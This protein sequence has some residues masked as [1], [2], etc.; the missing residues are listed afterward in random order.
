MT[1]LEEKESRRQKRAYWAWIAVCIS[2]GTTFLAARIAIE[3]YPPLLM[4]GTRH[5]V[6]GAVLSVFVTMR[7]VRLPPRESWLGHAVVGALMVGAGNGFLI[8][9]QQFVPS[10]VAAVMASTIP[11]WMVGVEA[12]M[13]GGEHLRAR[14]L[15]GLLIGFGG[16][17]L[18]SSS[19]V[20]L[21]GVGD[22]QF[23]LGVIALQCS[24]CG[25]AIGSAWAKRHKREEN[26]L[27]A[28]A[29]QILFG[30]LLQFLIGT[31]AGEWPAWHYTLRS[32]LG[33]LYLLIVGSFVG[34]VS[35]TYA[36]RHL[37]IS[38]V[39][40]YAYVN[41]VIAVILGAMILSEPFTPRMASAIAIIFVAMWIV[42]PAP[43]QTLAD[44]SRS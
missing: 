18:L 42:R 25:W 17:L 32:T 2:W 41:P 5:I 15:V 3:S 6:A 43:G 31:V 33:W 8:W 44:T 36:L 28:T 16:I 23:V 14:Q 19:G 39:S 26:V 21:A 9:A 30:G 24:C 22:R 12:S 34:Y 4:A 35:F 10:S 13:P 38:T 29:L 40:L 1:S 11:F 37:P 7:G 20:R 27:A